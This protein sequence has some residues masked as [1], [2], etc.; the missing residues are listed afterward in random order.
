[1]AIRPAKEGSKNLRTA[2]ALAFIALAVFVGFI[3]HSWYLNH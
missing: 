3:V 2:L 1:M